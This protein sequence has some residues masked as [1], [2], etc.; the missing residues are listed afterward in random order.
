MAWMQREPLRSGNRYIVRVLWRGAVYE[1]A[2]FN[3]AQMASV[4][5]QNLRENIRILSIERKPRVSSR[6]FGC[7]SWFR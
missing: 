5:N 1:H 2:V 4:V 3:M 6:S 7:C